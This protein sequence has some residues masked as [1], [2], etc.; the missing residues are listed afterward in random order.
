M[1]EVKINIKIILRANE[2]PYLKTN[3]ELYVYQQ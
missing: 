2:F 3:L 1:F